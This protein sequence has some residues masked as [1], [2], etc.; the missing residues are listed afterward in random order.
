VD[1]AV[2]CSYA[3]DILANLWLADAGHINE[4]DKLYDQNFITLYNS[5][6]WICGNGKRRQSG[7][8][9]QPGK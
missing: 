3:G 2:N 8:E 5:L 9:S 1:L 7:S 6:V 4:R